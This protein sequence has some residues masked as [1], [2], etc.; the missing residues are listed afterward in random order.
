MIIELLVQII[1]N[2]KLPLLQFSCVAIL[3]II[4]VMDF[5]HFH[6]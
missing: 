3:V 1:V 5:E 6:A 2:I 4:I